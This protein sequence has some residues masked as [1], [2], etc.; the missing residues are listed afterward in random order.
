MT[1][2]VITASLVWYLVS[3]EFGVS[4][5][6]FVDFISNREEEGQVFVKLMMLFK[7]S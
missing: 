6:T 1:D 2:I 5:I 7:R 4:V 3:L